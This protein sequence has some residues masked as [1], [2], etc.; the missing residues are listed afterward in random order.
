MRRILEPA[1]V[2]RIIWCGLAA[3]LGL[4]TACAG[5]GEGAVA[6][7][8]RWT[9]IEMVGR[10][11][12]VGEVVDPKNLSGIAFVSERFG[13]IGADEVRVVQAVEISRPQR[14]LRVLDT[15]P[16][17]RSGSEIDIEAIAAEGDSYYITGSHGASKK[18]GEEQD[19]RFSI[20]RLRVDPATG[21]PRGFK[22][23]SSELPDGLRKASLSDVIRAD[24][25]LGPHFEQPL[26]HQ[27]INIEGLAIRNGQLFVGFR[28]PNLGGYAF[29]M[30]IR[31]DDLFDAKPRPP[32]IL[33]RLQLG[34]GLGIREIVAV[35][36]GFLLIAGNAGSEPSKK[37]PQSEDYEEGRGF[38]LCS[39]DGKGTAVHQIGALPKTDGKAEAMAVL[40]ETKDSVTVLILFDGPNRGQPTVY[41]IS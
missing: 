16:L 41:R 14:T 21:L 1:F 17:A 24:P 8:K 10:Y 19:N 37:Y 32:Y 31:A 15:I 28:N 36:S 23:G 3:S 29:V 20:F 27:G 7:G 13:L 26:Q 2:L 39:W 38:F 35:R 5:R 34:A 30:E 22:A 11:S 9:R 18:K 4:A 25:V 33:H 40:E 12:L 6:A